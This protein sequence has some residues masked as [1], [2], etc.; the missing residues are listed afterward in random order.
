MFDIVTRNTCV[1][2]YIDAFASALGFFLIG[3]YISDYKS[4][5]CIKEKFFDI[6]DPVLWFFKVLQ[7]Y[8]LSTAITTTIILQF[9]FASNAATILGGC[10]VTNT[11][12][13]RIPAVFISAFIIS[14][15]C[16]AISFI[17]IIGY[18]QFRRVLLILLLHYSFG[19]TIVHLTHRIGSVNTCHV[20]Q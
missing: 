13:L 10:L 3:Y 9:T 14:V 19:Q 18:T 6:T 4:P 7:C 2:K 8:N 17:I 15:S 11:Y 12:K 5:Q 16:F 20:I 1:Q